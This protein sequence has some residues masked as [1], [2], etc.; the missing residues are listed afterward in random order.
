MK[1]KLVKT[2][3]YWSPDGQKQYFIVEPFIKLCDE[4][5]DAI[6]YN[7]I[8]HRVTYATPIGEDV[9]GLYYDKP[10]VVIGAGTYTLLIETPEICILVDEPVVEYEPSTADYEWLYAIKEETKNCC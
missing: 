3:G 1:T 10:H 8:A 7:G 6:D 2:Y 4:N 5:G 9:E